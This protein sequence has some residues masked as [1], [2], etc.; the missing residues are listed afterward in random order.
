MPETQGASP[1]DEER[2]ELQAIA[3]A[4]ARYP[5][6]VGLALYLGECYLQG[7]TGEINEYNIATQ[8]FGRSKTVFNSGE[9][10][11][12]RVETYRL[13]KRLKEYYQAEGKD[14]LVQMVIPSGTY[15]PVFTR[16]APEI[17]M[18][19][20]VQS[21]AES[22][23]VHAAPQSAASEAVPE[24]VAAIGPRRPR[25]VWFYAIPVIALLLAIPAV[26]LLFHRFSSSNNDRIAAQ[27]AHSPAP[28]QALS[29]HAA[30]LPLRLIAG[31][32]GTPQ[33]DNAGYTWQPDKYFHGGSTWTRSETTAVRTSNPL[34]F[35]QWRTG[36]FSY[37][38]PLSPGVYELHLYF[39]ASNREDE[40]FATFS[41]SINGKQILHDFDIVTDA[42]GENIADE[43]V[44]RDV[45]PAGD[46][47]LHIA[48]VS[49]RG[50]PVLN[51]LEI[52]PGTPHRQTPIRLITQQVPYDDHEGN[53]WLPDTY[54]ANGKMAAR[55]R[56][57]EGTSDP[58]LYAGERYGHFSYAIPVDPNGRYTLILHFAEFYFGPA[59]QGGGG[60]GN[61]LFRVL[62]NGSTL[63]DNF[64]IFSE[65]GSY[66]A[67]T[68]SFHHL[69]P[70]AQGKLNLTFEPVVNYATLSALEVIDE[71]Q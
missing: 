21:A 15:I 63:L 69:K 5:R 19:A 54:Y 56:P 23:I 6:L 25:P 7:N 4:L 48:F 32:F 59:V 41:M 28:Q 8:V 66:H 16:R 36:D 64:D 68:K 55:P 47:L 52:L 33:I 44:F 35:R 49:E 50:V 39:I 53:R 30:P 1:F 12:V 61:R 40:E 22:A 24:A 10:S 38:I 17:S 70:S 65:A 11:I 3:Q 27:P 43:R 14:H 2:A 20:S 42:E 29:V 51:A 37:E 34:L 46:G 45:S 31:Y 62:C 67:L 9:D 13:R 26:L 18:P 58:A 71:G 60:S 57:V